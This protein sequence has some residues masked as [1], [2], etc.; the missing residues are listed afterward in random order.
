MKRTVEYV[1]KIAGFWRILIKK[2]MVYYYSQNLD[3]YKILHNG[4]QGAVFLYKMKA[5]SSYRKAC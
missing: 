3:S 5:Q 2:R 1:K 4:G